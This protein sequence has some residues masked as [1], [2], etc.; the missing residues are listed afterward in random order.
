MTNNVHKFATEQSIECFYTNKNPDQIVD[1]DIT[2][3]EPAIF[4]KWVCFP[5]KDQ[6]ITKEQIILVGTVGTPHLHY[7]Y[8]INK[9]G[10]VHVPQAWVREKLHPITGLVQKLPL[11]ATLRGDELI[12]RFSMNFEDYRPRDKISKEAASQTEV[13]LVNF[14]RNIVKEEIDDFLRRIHV[15]I[16]PRSPER[17]N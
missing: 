13:P 1:A 6:I 16:L 2:I 11:V 17:S 15:Y 12:I 4:N 8:K 7:S 5:V 3:R 10:R 9:H 14:V